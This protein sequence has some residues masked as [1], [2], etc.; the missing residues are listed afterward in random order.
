MILRRVRLPAKPVWEASVAYVAGDYRFIISGNLDNG[1]IWS[2]TWASRGITNSTER[3]ACIPA[4]HSFYE[5]VYADK[6][7]S[8]C[9]AVRCVSRNLF[10]DEVVEQAWVT[11]DG[12]D[13]AD[14]LPTQCAVRVSLNSQD[15][16]S[17]GPF[18]AGWSVNAAQED[19]LL[20]PFSATVVADAMDDLANDLR[21]AGA[22]GLGV[23]SI[24]DSVVYQVDRGRV[25]QRF[26][27]IRKRANDL[28]ESY[29]VRFL[30]A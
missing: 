3:D 15:G 30:N 11:I 21:T 10:T 19:G 8:H 14:L 13:L 1:E 26:D 17:G 29:A 24:K 18:I 23:D 4:F 20:E 5:A 22:F 7:S 12:D 9:H 25:G 2:N 6:I 28:A 16:H 27:V